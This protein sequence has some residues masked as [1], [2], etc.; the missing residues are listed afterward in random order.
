V[1][2]VVLDKTGTLTFGRPEV[3]ALVPTAGVQE[4]ELLEAAAAAE[5]RSEHPLGKAIVA[6]AL[7][8]GQS[9]Q[10]PERFDYTPGRGIAAVVNGSTVLV[11]NS[12]LMRD[13][14][15]D[16]FTG[17]PSASE[18]TSQALVARDGRLLGTIVIADAIRPEARR[19]IEHIDHMSIRSI[20]LSGDTVPVA[21][22]VAQSLGIKEFK[23]GMLPEAKLAHVERLV[24]AGRG[25]AMVGD[26]I[27]DAPALAKADVGVAMGSGTDVARESADVVLL[28]NDLLKFAETLAIAR[29]TRKIIWQNFVG[30]VAVDFFA[31]FSLRSVC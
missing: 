23:A 5:L 30:T 27:N 7:S 18:T 11:G 28:G 12:A 17:I 20:L 9:I 19:A 8:D 13:R 16:P 6:R 24:A 22:A 26:G 14:G 10:E 15:I 1:N 2:T 4:I 29:R 25:V 3:Q 31:S 21:R